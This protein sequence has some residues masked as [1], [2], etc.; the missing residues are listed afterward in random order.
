MYDVK[1]DP[2]ENINLISNKINK[3]KRDR[4]GNHPEIKPYIIRYDWTQIEN[5][6]KK[7]NKIA[8]NFYDF[9]LIP[10]KST[11]DN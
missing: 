8:K 9:S 4:F 11:P 1:T 5:T 7:L 10:N 6:H 3:L 2:D